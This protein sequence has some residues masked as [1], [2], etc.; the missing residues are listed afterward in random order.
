[1]A[2]PGVTALTSLTGIS[3]AL[4]SVHLIEVWEGWGEELG[5]NLDSLQDTWVSLLVLFGH[6]ARDTA[7]STEDTGI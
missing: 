4:P 6:S 7:L 2:E 5:L 3:E 1:M